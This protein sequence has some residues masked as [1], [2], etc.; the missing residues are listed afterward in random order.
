MTA[1]SVRTRSRCS[2]PSEAPWP[3]P[4]HATTPEES[5]ACP[6]RH[7]RPRPRDRP[8]DWGPSTDLLPHEA[9]NLATIATVARSGAPATSR[10]CSR[11]TRTTSSGAT[12][13]WTRSTTARRPSGRS[14]S[15]S[16]SPLPDLDARDHPARPARQ[17]RRRGVHHPRH[18]PRPDVRPAGDRPALE[19]KFMSLLELRDGKMKEDHFYFDVATAMRQMGYFPESSAAYKLPGRRRARAGQPRDPPP[20]PLS[21]TA[22]R[23]RPSRFGP[24]PR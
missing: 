5:R 18:A 11:T 22:R 23:R 10:R 6:S 1:V 17:L 9:E 19:L 4:R 21:R 12:S 20:V 14:S 3:L 15:G 8:L 24:R 2:P 13:P 7:A 16:S